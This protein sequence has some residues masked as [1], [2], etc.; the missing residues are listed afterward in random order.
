VVAAEL[1]VEPVDQ[2]EGH[3]QQ[4]APGLLL[5]VVQPAHLD[6]RGNSPTVVEIR[7]TGRELWWLK[8]QQP[9]D[10]DMTTTVDFYLDAGCPWTWL[11]S[12]W[13]VDV[14]DQ[15]DLTV[16]WRPFSLALPERGQGAAPAARHPGVPEPDGDDRPRPPG[17]HRPRR[18]G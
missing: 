3:P 1:L 7:T 8:V 18:S 12:R 14:A 16:R 10:D 17:H 15:R 5:L 4:E 2:G 9:E 11:A 6:P 13:L